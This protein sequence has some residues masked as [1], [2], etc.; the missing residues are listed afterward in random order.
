MIEDFCATGQ[1]KDYSFVD[2]QQ[3]LIEMDRG[4][5]ETTARYMCTTECPCP[6]T[7]NKALWNEE[8]VRNFTRTLAATDTLTIEKRYRA[9]VMG[10]NRTYEK[11]WDC[12]EYL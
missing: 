5:T 10:G 7:L 8:Q 11:F 12:Y 6:T 9:F 2:L 3:S 1:I 4:M